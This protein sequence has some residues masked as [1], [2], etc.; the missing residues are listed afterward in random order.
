MRAPDKRL[1]G[2]R[3]AARSL[4]L[5]FCFAA[6][7]AGLHTIIADFDWWF[8][9]VLV[10]LVML[11][12]TAGVRALTPRRWA[13]PLV[14]ALGFLGILTA[15]FAPRTAFLLV[16][17]TE[18]TWERFGTLIGRGS[19][20]IERQSVPA[21]T[22]TEIM[23][24]LCLAVGCLVLLADLLA[25]AILTPAVAGIP[26]LVVLAIPAVTGLDRTDP[27]VFAL[28]AVAYL[29]LLRSGSPLH[30]PALSLTVGA[31]A[32]TTALIAPLVLPPVAQSVQT[33]DRFGGLLAGVNPVLNLGTD[34]RRELERTLLTYTTSSGDGH[35]LRLVSLQN[36]TAETWA[37]DEPTFDT[38]NVPQRMG[39]PPG[40]SAEVPTE[41]ESV[42]LDIASLGSPW[43]PVPY[44]TTGISGLRGDWFWDAD[45]LTLTSPDD[46]ARG[47]DYRAEIL[48]VQ[49]TPAQLVTAGE[50]VPVGFER[51]TGLPVDLPPVIGEVARYVASDAASSY[52]KA[53]ALQ[54]FFRDGEFSY[55]EQAPVEQGY[56]GNGMDVI[57][58][59]LDVKSGY[60]VHFSSAMAVMA[61]TLG[62]PARVAVGMLPGE[63][64]GQLE[65]GREVI[66]VT[67]ADL[68]AWP[69]LYFDGI[70][71]IR[72]EPTPG[73]GFVPTYA[74]EETPGV[75]QAP[76]PISPQPTTTPT[77]APSPS[78][79]TAP[80]ERPTD[81]DPAGSES[82]TGWLWFSGIVLGTVLLL[83]IPAMIRAI[84]RAVRLSR[85][86]RGQSLADTGWREVLQTA[87]DLGKPV[88]D[89]ATPR[90]AARAL[91]GSA[92]VPALAGTLSAIEREAYAPPSSLAPGKRSAD[93][94]REVLS[95]LHASAS[96]NARLRALFAPRSIWQPITRTR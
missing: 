21:V 30:Q 41:S 18:E 4:A 16:V 80:G 11:G 24:I 92:P 20:S 93:Q 89:T 44:P 7:L 38:A 9:L 28:T 27:V 29:V 71:W 90:V 10:A 15:F 42:F 69:E 14:G 49:P 26:V 91:A 47:E 81:D 36:F 1:V 33:N 61:R 6:A 17:P 56:D 62:I 35:Y 45:T 32:V 34:L 83:L 2:E 59:F 94:V 19:D 73:R 66:R 76:A 53:I 51:Y 68:H 67:T 95:G 3:P 78:A 58:R 96:L 31:L 39:D 87:R 37:P 79:T 22:D 40:L 85:L 64:S 50:A 55:S 86:E 72:F 25:N 43:L 77:A 5:L 57:E 60:C 12:I 52:E 46:T 65:G 84:Q 82:G 74:D 48:S 75:P 88:A 13:P 8:V 54:E 23:F 63:T 70:G